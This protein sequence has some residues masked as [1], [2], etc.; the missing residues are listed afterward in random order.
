VNAPG[1][2]SLYDPVDFEAAGIEL[3]F[4]PEY[5]GPSTS[6]LGRLMIEDRTIFPA[7]SSMARFERTWP[8]PDEGK[9]RLGEQDNCSPAGPKIGIARRQRLSL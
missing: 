2:R 4:L 5:Q 6:I 9:S 1:G 8:P 3:C 7:I